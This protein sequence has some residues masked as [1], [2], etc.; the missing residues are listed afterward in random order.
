MATMG[1]IVT[2]MALCLI[3]ALLTGALF[4]YLYAKASAKSYYED[5]IDA[6]QELCESK[7]KEADRVKEQ[8]GKLEIKNAELEEEAE[9]CEELLVKCR[10]KEE[11]MLTQLDVIAQENESLQQ[12]LNNLDPHANSHEAV[13]EEL[14]KLK[15]LL[16]EKDTG[17]TAKIKEDLTEDLN[18]AEEML[19]EGVGTGKIASFLQSLFGKFKAD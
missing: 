18:R 6:L 10:E 19:K 2:E 17:L 14:N 3:L 1:V 13:V 15:K 7:R 9:R 5:K 16:N 8:Y 12:K 11:E 4:A